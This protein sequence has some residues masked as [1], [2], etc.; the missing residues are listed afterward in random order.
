M[1]KLLFLALILSGCSK[2]PTFQDGHYRAS[3]T[4]IV[5]LTVRVNRERT[6]LT[7]L[8]LDTN[9][10]LI[11]YNN[12]DTSKPVLS[13]LPQRSDTIDD[14]EELTTQI[15]KRAG[16]EQFQSSDLT[17]SIPRSIAENYLTQL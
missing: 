15:C 14:Q 10:V 17:I 3:E 6:L 5:D 12:S 13:F 7:E 8:T 11:P 16:I 4:F 9:L 1:K 2:I